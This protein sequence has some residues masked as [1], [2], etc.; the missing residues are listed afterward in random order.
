MPPGDTWRCLATSLVA[1][2]VG[3]SGGT[4]LCC[5]HQGA[6]IR[7]LASGGWHQGC[8][9]PPT[10]CSTA[11][12]QPRS[13]KVPRLRSPS[14]QHQHL[15]CPSA[16]AVKAPGWWLWLLS[17]LTPPRTSPS[18][19]LLSSQP[20]GFVAKR[21]PGFTGLPGVHDSSDGENDWASPDQQ[22]ARICFQHGHGR[23]PRANKHSSQSSVPPKLAPHQARTMS[24]QHMLLRL[25]V[26]FLYPF[27]SCK[28]SGAKQQRT[29]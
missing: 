16:P 5:W 24:H 12:P 2:A 18:H 11:P 15:P 19:C 10:A 20:V 6:G 3:Q 4:E 1:L 9:Q 26:T 21:P 29:D 14:C 13:S 27:I 22:Q 7:G 25:T 17:D 8:C 23:E 28:S